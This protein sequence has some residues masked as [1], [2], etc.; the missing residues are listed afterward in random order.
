MSLYKGKLILK[1]ERE[2][3][4][5]KEDNEDNVE[6]KRSVVRNKG[7]QTNPLIDDKTVNITLKSFTEYFLNGLHTYGTRLRQALNNSFE[8]TYIIVMLYIFLYNFL[9]IIL[10][11]NFYPWT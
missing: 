3:D 10:H 8:R 4:G 1:K 9:G 11:V 7:N 6:E 5:D 2:R